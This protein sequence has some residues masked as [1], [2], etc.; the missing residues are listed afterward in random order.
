MSSPSSLPQF[1]DHGGPQ[2]KANLKYILHGVA[3]DQT[4]KHFPPHV[5]NDYAQGSYHGGELQ[6]GDYDY[7]HEGMK[8]DAFL[9]HEHSKIAKLEPWH[10]RRDR[11]ES[12][13][14]RPGL[15]S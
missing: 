9:N 13:A 8:F 2:D 10:V 14:F 11:F 1:E 12:S 4:D 15:T 3:Q 7:G 5:L 6:P